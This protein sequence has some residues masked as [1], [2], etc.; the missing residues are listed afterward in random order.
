MLGLGA[1][2]GTFLDPRGL[3]TDQRLGR[4]QPPLQGGLGQR[5]RP[6]RRRGSRFLHGSACRGEAAGLDVHERLA[7][8]AFQRFEHA[9][10]L[11]GDAAETGPVPRVELP[12]QDLHRHDP[13][14]VALVPLEHQGHVLERQAQL[15]EVL[16]QV[17]QARLV[18]L[19]HLRL[20]VRHEDD[21]VGA[22]QH[23]LAGGVVEH[24]AR[25]GVELQLG[26]E[27][28]DHPHVHGQQIEE[29]GAVRVRV[30]GDH[31]A[32]GL[33][34]RLPMDRAEVGGL[35][36][37][38]GP[39][40][41]DLDRH[42]MGGVVEEHHGMSPRYGLIVTEFPRAHHW[43]SFSPLP[44]SISRSIHC[45]SACPSTAVSSL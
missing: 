18:R 38:A 22:L 28:P 35:P 14:E 34:G 44:S 25:H 32:P 20:A 6:G 8:D 43:V 24:L 37:E 19:Q 21:A 31:L 11:A 12:F 45:T 39:V 26:P 30:E 5:P 16:L 42:L 17:A 33:E 7:R 1:G 15:R 2:W 27:A 29:Q 9:R 41:D 23:E 4:R 3:E 13:A 36:A 10:T 40:V